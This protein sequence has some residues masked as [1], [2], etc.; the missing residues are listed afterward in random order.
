MTRAGPPHLLET[1]RLRLVP[2]DGSW[3]SALAALYADPAVARHLGGEPAGADGP[4]RQVEGFAREWEREGWGTSA[5]LDRGTGAF[6][7]RAGL[8]R[9]HP[10]GDVELGYVLARDRWGRGLARE[11][12][13]AWL[14]WADEH[15]PGA[16]PPVTSVVVEVEPENTASL[17]LAHRL[18]FTS[19]RDDVTSRG[20]PVVVWRRE[21]L[22]PAP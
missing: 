16:D 10:G 8:H 5:L 9:W 4:A 22:P 18:G 15:L 17:R 13:Q 20:V 1:P 6:V 2:L 7:G 12:A 11:A 21:L 14:D 19:E 3:T